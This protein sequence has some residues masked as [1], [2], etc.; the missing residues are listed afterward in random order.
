MSNE[1]SLLPGKQI[2]RF[3]GERCQ[4]RLVKIPQ[5]SVVTFMGMV[6]CGKSSL[7]KHVL[8]G[9]R[10]TFEE[11]ENMGDSLFYPRIGD[12]E[13]CTSGCWLYRMDSIHPKYLIDTEGF[14]ATACLPSDV[15]FGNEG[16]ESYWK[17][18]IEKRVKSIGEEFPAL[19]FPL[20][21][22]IVFVVDTVNIV[23]SLK[24]FESMKEVSGD[25]HKPHLILAV[26]KMTE[27]GVDPKD[28]YEFFKRSIKYTIDLE[29]FASFSVVRLCHSLVVGGEEKYKQDLKIL[30][31]L[32]REKMF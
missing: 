19:L 27:Y 10:F 23:G 3:V 16:T 17:G 4:P 29:N 12:D 28:D 30:L 11:I 21:D 15:S 7:A 24:A 25:D 18:N 5:G 13:S 9:D 22:V 14:N 32:I 1:L 2:I 26:N 8:L 20:S 31:N 6:A